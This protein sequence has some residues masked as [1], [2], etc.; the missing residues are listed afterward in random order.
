MSDYSKSIRNALVILTVVVVF[1][2][3]RELSGLLIPLVLAALLTVLGLPLVSF[4]DKRRVPGF[5]ITL[6]VAAA[7]LA[8]VF[9]VV[10]LISATVQQLVTDQAVL[11][12]QFSRKINI[13]LAAL[14]ESVPSIGINSMRSYLENAVSPDRVAGILGAVLGSLGSFGSSFLLFIVYYL[15]L[16]SGATGYRAYMDYVTGTDESGHARQIWKLTHQS[17]SAY[18]SIKTLISLFT[19]FT[20]GIVCWAFG[21]RFPLFWGFLAFIMNFIPSIGSLLA[22]VLPVLMA[23]IQFDRIGIIVALA[24]LLGASQFIIGSVIDPMV[25]GNRLRLNTV[26]VIFGLLFWGYIWGIPGMLLSVPLMV[27][28]RLMLERSEDLAIIARIMGKPGRS[29][30]KRPPLISR[31]LNRSLKPEAEGAV[32]PGT[33]PEKE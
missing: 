5:F 16:I 18:V 1:A 29:G 4:L 27:M 9:L 21:L 25:M 19:G 12:R 33:E 14:E 23:I 6:I 17:L 15:I 26:T 28:I 13:A 32:S 22:T 10:T 24:V 2:V 3:L 30:R 8:L 31:V 11:A 7:T 20:V